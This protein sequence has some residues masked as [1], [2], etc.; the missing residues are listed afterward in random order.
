MRGGP[1]SRGGNAR[2]P[3]NP[4][5]G[6]VHHTGG[7]PPISR[8]QEHVIVRYGQPA[9]LFEIVVE[10]FHRRGVQGDQAALPKLGTAD[11]QDADSSDGEGR[12]GPSHRSQ[13]R[14]EWLAD[15]VWIAGPAQQCRDAGIMGGIAIL[16]LKA[17]LAFA[18]FMAEGVQSSLY[19]TLFNMLPI[20]PLDGSKLLLAARVPIRVYVELARYD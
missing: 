1:C 3:K 13:T 5:E 15:R 12:S 4:A 7:D 18:N 14:V 2:K 11:L 8:R 17:F 10:G 19:L 6:V 20:P 16:T 9:A